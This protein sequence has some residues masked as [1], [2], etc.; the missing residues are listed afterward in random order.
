MSAEQAVRDLTRVVDAVC[1]APLGDLPAAQLQALAVALRSASGRLEGKLDQTLAAVEVRGDGM[2]QV[3]AHVPNG[4]AEVTPPLYA[5]VRVWWRESVTVSGGQAGRDLRRCE[6]ASRLTVISGAV[7]EGRLSPEQSAVLYRLDGKIPAADLEASQEA[8]V[9]LAASMNPEVL[10]QWVRHLIATHCEPALDAEHDKALTRRYLQ[11]TRHP[12]GTV[13]GRF[14]LPDADAEALFT[15]LE[16]LARRA[17]LT[18]KRSAG[19][20]RADALVEVFTAAL[21]WMDLP[22][23]GGQRP[24]LVCV[25]PGGWLIGETGPSLHDL[26]THGLLTPDTTTNPAEHPTGVHPHQLEEHC[27]TSPWTGPQP[28]HRVDALL[29]DSALSRV[30]KDPLGQVTS[31]QSLTNQITTA[32]RKALAARD[33]HCTAKGCHRPPAFCD[34]HHLVSRQNGGATSMDNLTLLC[35]RHHV[36]WHHGRLT[37]HDLHLPWLTHRPDPLGPPH[38]WHDTG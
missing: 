34:A 12:D 21:Q 6:I 31:L 30:F 29:C 38:L 15:V 1:G 11:T 24:Q 27:A 5:P 9:V 32:Q 16:P 19:Q 7:T 25:L 26:L 10:A 36:L 17:G 8:L 35:R 33:R 18:D 4:L 37:L 20:R 2:V 22:Q 14:V 3:N 28:R 13:S 23:A